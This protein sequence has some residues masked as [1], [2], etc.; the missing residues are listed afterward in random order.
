MRR[1]ARTTPRAGV[2][3][4]KSA[5]RTFGGDEVKPPIFDYACPESLDEALVLLAQHGPDAK[6][7]AGGQSLM[8]LLNFRMLR[9]SILIDINRIAELAELREEAAGLRIGALTR[10]RTLESSPLVAQRFPVLAAAM[11]HVAHL[12]I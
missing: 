12:A 8:P 11:K 10:H 4:R 9:P 5:R 7:L 1:R 6:V 3:S 2:R